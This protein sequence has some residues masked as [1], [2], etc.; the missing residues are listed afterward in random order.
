MKR[1]AIYSRKSIETDK[2]ESIKNQIEMC[3]SYFSRHEDCIFEI[4]ED[5]GF[6]GGNTNRPSF[7]RMMELAKFKQFDVI[8]VYKVDRIARNIVDFVNIYDDLEKHDVKLVSVTEG[9]DPSTP[10]GKMMMLLLASFAEMERMN[11]QQRVKDNMHALAKMGRWSGGTPPTGYR[12]TRISNGKKTEVY[13]ELIPEMKQTI[14]SIFN[15][16]AEGITPFTISKEVN[17]PCKTISNMIENPT[18]VEATEESAN[19]LKSLGY[20]VFG[21]LN[22]KG[23]LV[24]NRRPR[25]NGVKLYNA[26]G[27]L[28]S[29]SQHEAA[30][31]SRTWILANEK[32]K[33]RG[34]ESHPRISPNSF[35]A[36]MVKCSCGSGMTVGCGRTRKDGSRV[37]YFMCSHKKTYKDC[38]SNWLRVDEV[39][40]SFLET[41]TNI[42]MDKSVLKNYLHTEDKTDYDKLI[43]ETKNKITKL[44]S[45]INNLT[46]KLILLEGDAI[47]IVTDKINDLAKE[48]NSLNTKLL[49]IER[50]KLFNSLDNQNISQLSAN[51]VDFVKNFDSLDT[52]RRQLFIQHI[53]KE[54]Q[55]DGKEKIKIKFLQ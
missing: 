19:Y 17:I 10:I 32:I 3:K 46:D 49:E 24:F 15:K 53:I 44:S 39:E 23:F 6:S 22:G 9:F 5:E 48:K 50:K 47:N 4:F 55:W 12:S 42:S 27:M 26:E 7:Q 1:I 54:I 18:Y 11:I 21:E 28:V 43:K 30:I 41:L 45:D 52:N 35:L 16:A 33:S 38:N 25:K 36:H 2:G 8:A 34:R 40:E 51:I 31:D 29:S 20:E 14:N 13:L 37:R